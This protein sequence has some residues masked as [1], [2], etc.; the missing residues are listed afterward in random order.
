MK[1]TRKLSILADIL[2]MPKAFCSPI[3]KGKKKDHVQGI[4]AD[5]H[6]LMS[7]D[8]T[9]MQLNLLPSCQSRDASFADGG[10]SP[11][12]EDIGEI[13]G[14]VN[15]AEVT[16]LKTH[17]CG[18]VFLEGYLFPEV[19]TAGSPKQMSLRMSGVQLQETW[20]RS[21]SLGPQ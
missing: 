5:A 21:S 20:N 14:V 1:T 10:R 16:E 13:S 7:T 12:R 17:T 15:Q 3:G 6:R 2:A 9:V 4:P 18:V 11:R 19:F 8:L